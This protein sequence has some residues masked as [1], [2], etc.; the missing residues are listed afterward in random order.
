SKH[1]E[2]ADQY[3]KAALMTL[4]NPTKEHLELG[5]KQNEG[6]LSLFGASLTDSIKVSHLSNADKTTLNQ[7]IDKTTKA[8]KDFVAAL[9]TMNNDKNRTWKDFKIGKDLFAQ[10]F[11]F[12]V[13]IDLTPEQIYEKAKADK[14]MYQGKM[15]MLADQLW[16]K[17]YPTTGKPKED[18]KAVQMV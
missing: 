18:M 2:H 14:K 17:Y 6:G 9:K 16:K 7:N 5:M 13:A 3:Y 8:I 4:K 1:L 11:K 15:I 12:D 10:K